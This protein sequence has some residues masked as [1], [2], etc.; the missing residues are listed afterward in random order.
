MFKSFAKASLFGARKVML[1]AD[2]RV[3]TILGYALR[4][5][6]MM[7]RLGLFDI[8]VAKLSSALVLTPAAQKPLY[9]F[10]RSC[11]SL[12]AGQDA[13]QGPPGVVLRVVRS[14]DWQKHVLYIACD[15][16]GAAGGRQELAA[17]TRALHWRAHAGK[18]SDV[19]DGRMDWANE[20]GMRVAER[21]MRLMGNIVIAVAVVHGDTEEG[22]RVLEAN[23]AMLSCALSSP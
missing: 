18:V 9:Q 23:E 17:W 22:V 14:A 20:E 3:C 21:R 4:K 16:T 5:V 8:T 15:V 6:E 10:S 2:A 19:A 1:T 12:A 13:A 11:R 7:V